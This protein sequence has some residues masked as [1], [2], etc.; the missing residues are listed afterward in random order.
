MTILLPSF[1]L[2]TLEA[3]SILRKEVLLT[4]MVKQAANLAS[5][6]I[7]MNT[8]DL[9]LIRRSL[10]DHVIEPQRK[11]LIPHFDIIQETALQLGALGCS[12]SGAGPSIFALCQ[13]K[14]QAVEIGTAMKRIYD[15]HKIESRL[16]TSGINQQGTIVM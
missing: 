14:T 16:M 15:Q 1:S 2:S 5:F 11:H 4:D 12:I 8:S 10:V 9:D 3:R 13:E 6:V 7:G